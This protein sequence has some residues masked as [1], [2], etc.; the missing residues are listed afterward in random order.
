MPPTA[1]SATADFAGAAVTLVEPGDGD[2]LNSRRTFSWQANFNLPAGYA[3]EPVFWRQGGTAMDNGRGFVGTTT[4]TS[5]ELQPNQFLDG[6]G[7]YIW[8]ILLVTTDPYTR[9]KYLGSERRIYVET[10]S[11]SPDN[12]NDRPDPSS[13]RDD[14]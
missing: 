12:G 6:S 4:T 7:E 8:G 13:T 11:D 9:I 2:T 5:S 3:F 14:G 1:T 10:G